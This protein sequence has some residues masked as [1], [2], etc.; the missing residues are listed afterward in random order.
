MQDEEEQ[1]KGAGFVEL[2]HVNEAL[3]A[4]SRLTNMVHLP[5]LVQHQ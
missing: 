5:L 4:I 3:P 2:Q 1:S